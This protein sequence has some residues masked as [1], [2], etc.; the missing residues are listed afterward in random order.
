MAMPS[1]MAGF[2]ARPGPQRPRVLVFDVDGTLID[3]LRPMHRALNEVLACEGLAP[4]SVQAVRDQLSQGLDG[5]LDAALASCG[6][7]P[8]VDRKQL[9]A[10][11]LDRY[12]GVVPHEARCYPHA[13]ALLRRAHEGG[14]RLAVCSNAYGA[15]I[16]VLLE[17]FGWRTLFH[18]VIH[19]G[20]AVA[21]KPSGLPLQQVL[22]IV[23]V[24]PDEAWMIGDSSLDARC[25]QA[26]GCAFVW[27]SAG[28]GALERSDPMLAR[29]DSHDALGELVFARRGAWPQVRDA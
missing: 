19:A 28:Y 14:Y 3:T 9:R 25:A 13:E 22:S 23:D 18:S 5:L 29:V 1:R 24:A 21:L 2:V 10:R 17:R 20:N 7:M 26:A 11:L 16:D 8:A 12:L 27:F 6:A 15:V 4:W